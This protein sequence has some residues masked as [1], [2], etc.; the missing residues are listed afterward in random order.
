MSSGVYLLE[1][2]YNGVDVYKIGFSKD[3]HKRIK[4]HISSNPLLKPIGYISTADYKWMESEIHYK[5][6]HL[7]MNKEW[8]FKREGILKEF[9]NNINFIC[10]FQK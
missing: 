7:R 6:R 4:T 1:C 3:V 2:N 9:E 10:L 8:F 5:C